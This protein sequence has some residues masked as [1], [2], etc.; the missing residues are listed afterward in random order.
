[1][2]ATVLLKD[3]KIALIQHLVLSNRSLNL[4]SVQRK[5]E[6]AAKS[7]AEIVILPEAFNTMYSTAALVENAEFV[8]ESGKNSPTFQFLSN[9]AKSLSIYLIGGSIP[10]KSASNLIYNTCFA[11]DRK[12]DLI[13]KHRKIHLFDVDIPGKITF[14]ES[15]A[16][17][18]GN[19]LTTISTEFGKIGLGICYDIRFPELAILAAAKKCFMMVYPGAF[20]MTTGP[21][22]W[23]LLL[24]SRAVDN[25]MYVAGVSPAHDATAPY[26]AWGHSALMDPFGKVLVEAELEETIL[27]AD[28]K[29]SDLDMYRQQVPVLVQKR[30]DCY[31]TE[32]LTRGKE[33]KGLEM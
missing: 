19:S 8:G 30:H 15:D 9:L 32:D 28:V 10:E 26:Q 1:M 5:V 17:S 14:K 13:G 22:H 25:Q 21:L 23:S 7:G 27:Y 2:A 20:N 11:Y 24:R 12:G 33:E 29:K 31:R 3:C 4:S 6:A 18:A 16:L